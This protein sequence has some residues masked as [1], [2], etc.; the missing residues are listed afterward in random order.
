M[1]QGFLSIALPYNQP[2]QDMSR[3]VSVVV[4]YLDDTEV[5][6]EDADEFFSRGLSLDSC[7]YIGIEDGARISKRMTFSLQ[8]YEPKN[9]APGTTA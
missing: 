2:T 3:V 9:R 6:R 4:T 1:K 8:T 5:R 7:T